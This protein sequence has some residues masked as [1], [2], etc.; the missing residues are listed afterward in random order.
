MLRSSL[1]LAGLLATAPALAQTFR[2]VNMIPASLSGETGRDTETNLAVNLRNPLQMAGSAFT[3]DPLASVLASPIFV[4]TDGGATWS[5]RTTVPSNNMGGSTG[6]ITLRF[7]TESNNLYTGTL[8]GGAGLTLNELRTANFTGLTL[9]DL[10]GTRANV[11]QPYVQVLRTLFSGT[12]RVYWPNNDFAVAPTTGT[13]DVTLDGQIG[14]PAILSQRLDAGP[15]T[16]QDMPPVRVALHPDGTVY[17]AFIRGISGGFRLI[18][19]RDDNGGTSSPSFSAIPGG[20]LARG[21]TVATGFQMNFL[22]AYGQQRTVASDLSIAVDP[23]NSQ[24]VFVAWCDHVSNILTLHLRTS[25]NGGQ[26][27]SATDDFTVTNGKCPALAVNSD[28]LLALAHYE[29]DTSTTPSTLRFHLRRFTPGGPTDHILYQAPDTVTPGSVPNDYVHLL[30]VGKNFF[31]VFSA[32]NR[33][34]TANFPQGVTFQRAANFAAHTLNNGSGGAVAVSWD[35]Y[36]YEVTEQPAGQDYFVRD[37][38]DSASIFDP[39]LEPSTRGVFYKTSD[40]WNRTS[41]TPGAFVNDQPANQDANAGVGIFGRNFAFARIRRRATTTGAPVTVSANFL[42]APFGTGSPFQ[43][44]N[45]GAADPTATFNPGDTGPFNVSLTYRLPP[46]ASNHVCMAVEITPT[47]VDPIK[48]GSLNG[49]TPGWPTTDLAVINDNNKAQRNLRS[50]LVSPGSLR[51]SILHGLVR[52]ASLRREDL[53]LKIHWPI[54]R[55]RGVRAITVETAGQKAVTVKN[56]SSFVLRRMAPGESRWVALKIADSG[57]GGASSLPVT[58]TNTHS[59]LPVNGFTIEAR[60]SKPEEFGPAMIRES[61]AQVSRMEA[62]RIGN[63]GDVRKAME[64]FMGVQTRP[65]RYRAFIA[66]FGDDLAK[67]ARQSIRGDDDMFRLRATAEEF[68]SD[69]RSNRI[70]DA[71]MSHQSLLN[72]LDS[73]LTRLLL[74]E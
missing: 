45:P 71:L 31:G 47:G 32:G 18:V 55:D 72:R 54:P 35:P 51:G 52:Q 5:L 23:L 58:F 70:G 50:V 66:R 8:R 65:S 49:Q 61:L 21:V 3:S 67:L 14:A 36:F 74:K 9:M 53:V 42:V 34:D 19:V 56:G 64:T 27:W 11:D 29:L 12:D 62:M 63:A 30:A 13:A 46:P 2:V 15:T 17:A 22:Q 1:L 37:W 25:T 39:G 60:R 57:M 43:D 4:S 44:I 73:H 38:T 16:S 33:P 24:N 69:R 68:S 7:G 59:N 26:N 40:V 6:D 20:G 10:L 28:G 48:G 41:N